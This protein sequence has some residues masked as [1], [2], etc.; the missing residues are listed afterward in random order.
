MTQIFDSLRLLV[1][2]VS[3]LKV[4]YPASFLYQV[5]DYP[6][7]D[8]RVMTY[9]GY[10]KRITYDNHAV[11]STLEN[12]SPAEKLVCEKIGFIHENVHE[13]LEIRSGAICSKFSHYFGVTKRFARRRP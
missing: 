8:F 11:G 4:R 10:C 2:T 9:N 12:I 1:L 7:R 6:G 5:K 3:S 13:K